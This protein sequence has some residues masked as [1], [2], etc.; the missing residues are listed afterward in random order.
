M[1]LGAKWTVEAFAI[2]FDVAPVCLA[3]HRKLANYALLD[4]TRLWWIRKIAGQRKDK[5]L[6]MNTCAQF[7]LIIYIIPGHAL[8][9]KVLQIRAGV[10]TL[11]S[12]KDRRV[13]LGMLINHV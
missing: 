13:F 9:Q 5:V 8:H 12:S 3:R 11:A 6:N 7:F 10:A 4:Q 1:P 2:T